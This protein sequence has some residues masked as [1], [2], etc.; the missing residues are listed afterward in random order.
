MTRIGLIGPGNVGRSLVQAL[1]KDRYSL[2]PV[3]GRTAGSARRL[4]RDLREGEAA[5]SLAAFADCEVI[6]VAVPGDAVRQLADGLAQVPF[7]WEGKV[8]LHTC[9]ECPPDLQLLADTGVAVAAL[10]PLQLFHRTRVHLKGIHFVLSGDGPALRVA[11][12]VVRAVGGHGHVVSRD[13]KAQAGVAA[14]IA[15]DIVSAVVEMAVRRLVAAGFSR[16]KAAQAIRPIV[17]TALEDFHRAGSRPDC[18]A[19]GDARAASHM[20]E[21]CDRDDPVDG[22]LYRRALR[23]A[24]DSMEVRDASVVAVGN[25]VGGDRSRRANAAG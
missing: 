18:S 7:S 2:G 1:P 6:F 24:C 8:L 16:R 13:A 17:D 10:Y 21:V 12:S 22:Q 14:S 9:P 4:V 19:I 23:L 5:S 20:A 3:L 15:S 11:R 25:A